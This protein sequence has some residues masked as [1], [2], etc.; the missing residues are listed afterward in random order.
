MFVKGPV[1]VL[2]GWCSFNGEVQMSAQNIKLFD[3]IRKKKMKERKKE[4]K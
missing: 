1:G 2:N 4:K 3:V